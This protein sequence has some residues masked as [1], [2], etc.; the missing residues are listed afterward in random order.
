[1]FL[2]DSRFSTQES[3][4]HNREELARVLRGVFSGKTREQWLQLFKNTDVPLSPVS[5]LGEAL[6]DPQIAHRGLVKKVTDPESGEVK[7]LDILGLEHDLF[8]RWSGL[9]E[10][11]GAIP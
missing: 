8:Q 4:L 5:T 9:S 6:S 10:H 7:V 2:G 11:E 1:M 3:R